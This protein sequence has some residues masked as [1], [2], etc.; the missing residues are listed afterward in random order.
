[1]DKKIKAAARVKLLLEITLP[2]VWG[3]ECSM[4]QVYKQA[5][6]SALNIISQRISGS[7]REMRVIGEAEVIAILSEERSD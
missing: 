4:S 1:M 6:D 7:M 2:D 3:E 5:K